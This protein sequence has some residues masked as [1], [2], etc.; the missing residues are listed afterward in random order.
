MDPEV[1]TSKLHSLGSAIRQA[2]ALY[3][4]LGR[5]PMARY[6]YQTALQEYQAA[7]GDDHPSTREMRQLYRKSILNTID[8]QPIQTPKHEPKDIFRNLWTTAQT[9]S[10]EE[11][12]FQQVLNIAES[13]I[14]S[15][16]GNWFDL[17]FLTSYSNTQPLPGECTA[18][19]KR[20]QDIIH[21][22]NDLYLTI[23]FNVHTQDTQSE[24][25][26]IYYY[27]CIAE[28]QATTRFQLTRAGLEAWT[29]V[30]VVFMVFSSM[31]T[32]F[33]C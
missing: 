25:R 8:V 5:L 2:G 7:F 14:K 6:M 28:E 32:L 26:R 33:A 10:Q 22:L 3:A 21:R 19:G 11:K 18:A 9:K 17:T 13:F 27:L 30:V 29:S 15:Q 31:T 12:G 16:F 1:L 24:F 4:E 23:Q 20:Q